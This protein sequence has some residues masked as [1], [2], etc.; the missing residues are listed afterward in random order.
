MNIENLKY[1]AIIFLTFFSCEQAE[2]RKS[3]KILSEENIKLKDSINKILSTKEKAFLKD[4]VVIDYSKGLLGRLYYSDTLVLSARFADCGEF[5]GHKEFLKI[6]SNKEKFQCLF[7]NKMVD[8]EKSYTDYV[9][10]D[11]TLFELSEKNQRSVIEYLSE[12]TEISMLEQGLSNNYSNDY[13]M[14]LNT[15]RSGAPYFTENPIMS[16]FFQDDSLKWSAY[17]KLREEIKTNANNTYNK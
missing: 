9:K 7:I 6:Y 4:S 12:L 15:A 3:V 13:E 14:V 2:S 5:G 8:C 10:I 17:I 11:S 16:L 1:F